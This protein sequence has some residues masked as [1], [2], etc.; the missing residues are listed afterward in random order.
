MT[1][2][3]GS[4]RHA[5]INGAA[6]FGKITSRMIWALIEQLMSATR[7]VAK[8]VMGKGGSHS[9]QA[10]RDRVQCTKVLLVLK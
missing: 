1:T 7:Y 5:L 4:K 6:F 8:D 2:E 10:Y 9:S 3:T